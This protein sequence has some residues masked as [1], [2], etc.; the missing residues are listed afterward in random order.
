MK[1]RR[2]VAVL[3]LKRYPVVKEKLN[4]AEEKLESKGEDVVGGRLDIF[5]HNLEPNFFLLLAY[6]RTEMNPRRTIKQVEIG[7]QAIGQASR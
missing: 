4:R 5:I 1:E 3:K 6:N 2:L 7:L